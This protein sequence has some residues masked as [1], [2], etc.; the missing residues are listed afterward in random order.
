[1]KKRREFKA[2]YGTKYYPYCYSCKVMYIDK[3]RTT[4]GKTDKIAINSFVKRD[5]VHDKKGRYAF[6]AIEQFHPDVFKKYRKGLRYM[7]G[8]INGKKMY[9]DKRYKYYLKGKDLIEHLIYAY[10]EIY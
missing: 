10:G 6:R 4:S 7:E 5:W 2:Y 1:M 8:Y 9:G 3:L